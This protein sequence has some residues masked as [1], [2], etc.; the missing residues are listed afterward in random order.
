MQSRVHSSRVQRPSLSW[1]TVEWTLRL[2]SK[3]AHMCLSE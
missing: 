3:V 1:T 2:R